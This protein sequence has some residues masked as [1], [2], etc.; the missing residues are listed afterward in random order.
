MSPF[1][2]LLCERPLLE[3]VNKRQ[4]HEIGFRERSEIEKIRKEIIEYD[5]PTV[6]TTAGDRILAQGVGD[7]DQ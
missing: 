3:V 2:L 1:L 7:A 6:G 4:V 5:Q